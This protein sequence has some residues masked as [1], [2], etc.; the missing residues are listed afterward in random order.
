MRRASLGE[1]AAT[2]RLARLLDDRVEPG[3]AGDLVGATESARLTDLGE[4]V[5]GEDRADTVDRLQRLA[6]PIIAGEAAQL[7]VNVATCASS[8]AITAS[9]ESTCRRACSGSRSAP[10]SADPPP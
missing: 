9:S 3:Q 2:A 8:A 10:A 4:Q 5:A 7:P 6:A 1:L